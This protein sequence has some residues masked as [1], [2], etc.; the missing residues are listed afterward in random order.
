M[1]LLRMPAAVA[2]MAGPYGQERDNIVDIVGCRRAR[3]W[4]TER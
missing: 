1:A 3:T 2:A 4:V